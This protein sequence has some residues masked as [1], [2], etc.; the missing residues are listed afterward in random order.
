[1]PALVM[2]VGETVTVDL[3][4]FFSDPDGGILTFAAASSAAGVLSVSLA[5]NM[6]TAAGV[7]AGTATVTVTATD[8]DGLTATQSRVATVERANE[9]PE[10]VGTI[11]GQAIAVG[12]T[13]T[14]DVVSFFSD[15]DGD[16]LTYT[17]ASAD[18]RVVAASMSGSSLTVT[19]VAVGTATVTVTAADPAGLTAAQSAEVTVEAANRAPEAV[20]AIP[21]RTISAGHAVTVD[22]SAFFTDPDGDELNYEAESSADSVITVGVSGSS[23]TITALAAGTATVTVTATDPGG[24]SATQSGGLTVEAANRAPQPVGAL[25][26]QR[27]TAGQAVDLDVSIFFTDPDGDELTYGVESSDAG[28]VSVVLSGSTLTLTA[29]A[30]GTATVTLTAT[31]PSGLSAT[32]SVGVTVAVGAGGF[33]DEFDSVASLDD[34][35]VSNADAAVT[36]GLLRLTPTSDDMIGVAE[37]SLEPALTEW[38]IRARLGRATSDGTVRVYWLTGDADYPAVGFSLGPAG[39]HNYR[40][41]FFDAAEGSWFFASNLSG[42]SDAVNDEP[43]EFTDFTIG[44]DGGQ[45][46]MAAGEI[47][48]LRFTP[49]LSF[50]PALRTITDIWLVGPE[51]RSAVHFDWVHVTGAV[52]S[53][54]MSSATRA[55]RD[56]LGH[57]ARAA[58]DLLGH[59]ADATERRLDGVGSNKQ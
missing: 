39:E 4:P 17:A 7:A 50:L 26:P 23:L 29:A 1:M 15:P 42:Y 10:A 52:S 6:M 3:A 36:D 46:F 2:T 33:R 24:L 11:P 20:G 48:I 9:A 55:A 38:T 57:A 58:R 12:Q 51:S 28:V 27:I 59:A 31:D 53:A 8:P 43:G 54:A 30:A 25:P 47:E 56:L 40:F 37:R 35:E 14:I 41:L 19:A 22:V 34:W 5:G 21:T 13:A 49:T 45:V 44:R 32:Q 18:A 16:E